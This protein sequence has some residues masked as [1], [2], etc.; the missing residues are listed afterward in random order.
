MF[1]PNGAGKST[2]LKI[3]AGREHADDGTLETRRG[4]RVGYVA[5]R[6]AGC[7]LF[8]CFHFSS[9]SIRSLNHCLIMLW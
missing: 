5:Q 7:G 1:G 4:V 9:R 2:F 3:L 6:I 8:F